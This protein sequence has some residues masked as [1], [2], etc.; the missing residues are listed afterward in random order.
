MTR[1]RARFYCPSGKRNCA[2][3]SERDRNL[4]REGKAPTVEEQLTPGDPCICGC[5]RIS[6]PKHGNAVGICGICDPALAERFEQLRKQD[7]LELSDHKRIVDELRAAW[8][9]RVAWSGD[10]AEFW[11]A[12]DRWVCRKEIESDHAV[13][14]EVIDLA[15]TLARLLP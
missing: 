3:C 15:C 14:S 12:V 1:S 4:W 9:K 6:C 7:V 10:P 11:A 8:N 13:L 2:A 5:A